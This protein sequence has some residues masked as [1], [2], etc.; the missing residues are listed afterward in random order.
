MYAIHF[1]ITAASAGTRIANGPAPSM[2][3]ASGQVGSRA[4][5]TTDPAA[6][7]IQN[8]IIAKTNGRFRERSTGRRCP[9]E[10]V[11]EKEGGGADSRIG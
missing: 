6:G 7:I 1:R 2:R 4:P 11:V 3:A 8:M 10:H 9:P 5:H